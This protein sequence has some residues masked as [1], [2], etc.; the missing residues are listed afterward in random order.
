MK[1]AQRAIDHKRIIILEHFNIMLMIKL[2]TNIANIAKSPL[3]MYQF[4]IQSTISQQL[5]SYNI[6]EKIIILEFIIRISYII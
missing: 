3:V 6:F 1:N 5:P 4:K 2:I